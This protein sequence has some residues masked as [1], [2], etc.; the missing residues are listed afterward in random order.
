[1][2]LMH[3]PNWLDETIGEAYGNIT[4]EL[5]NEFEVEGTITQ[6]EYKSYDGFIPF[7]NGG[8]IYRAP[9]N[10]DYLVGTG[11]G[12]TN[13]KVSKSIDETVGYCYKSALE[14]F[15]MTNRDELDGLFTAEELDEISDNINYHT[16]YEKDEGNLAERLSEA[17][18]NWLEGYLFVE[19]RTIFFAADNARN[20]TGKD[21]IYFIA[22]VNLD[23]DYG[24]DKG[25]VETFE[26]TVA[27]DEL[28]PA[29][30]NDIFK[31]MLDSI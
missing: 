9:I 7:T 17:E 11:K 3:I 13:E 16:L 24:R 15:I 26:E 19:V 10:L 31:K 30:V 14:D 6:I 8:E 27:V 22:G 21:E 4:E 28:T 18:S 12:F 20:I 2:E 25:L 1:M 23:Y 5:D 29:K